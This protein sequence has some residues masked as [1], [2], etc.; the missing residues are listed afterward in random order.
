MLKKRSEK[1]KTK[2][3]HL[4]LFFGE[5][6][7]R[8]SLQNEK[9]EQKRRATR[10]T[11]QNDRRKGASEEAQKKKR[12]EQYRPE[13]CFCWDSRIS[14]YAKHTWKYN[15]STFIRPHELRVAR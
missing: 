7:E 3:M 5:K 6:S 13:H 14:S 4:G 10:P 12:F 11:K 1:S 8:R 9:V 2:V 15:L